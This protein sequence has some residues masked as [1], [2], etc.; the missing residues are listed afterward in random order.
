MMLGFVLCLALFA[1]TGG[2]DDT[3][4]SSYQKGLA[5]MQAKDYS[6]AEAKFDYSLSKNPDSKSALYRKA[7]CIYKQGKHAEALPL[8]EDF[9]GKTD[10]NEWTATFIDERRDAQFFRDK[11]KLALGQE[12]PQDPNNIPE[13]PMGE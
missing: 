5:L 13:P 12:V 10:N 3:E 11:C 1:T 7:Y 4:R 9:L 2:C 6:G 8:F